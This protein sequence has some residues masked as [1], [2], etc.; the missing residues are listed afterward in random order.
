MLL[1]K[2]FGIV[3]AIV[4]IVLVTW[5]F[6]KKSYDAESGLIESNDMLKKLNSEISIQK[7]K[8]ELLYEKSDKL[9]LNILPEPIATRLKEGET[10]I[11]EIGR[12]HV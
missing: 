2:F 5:Y 12:A 11:A 4:I 9:L 1:E 8:I 7:E 3:S 10:Q 6:V